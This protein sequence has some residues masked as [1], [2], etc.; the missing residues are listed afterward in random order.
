MI[1]KFKEKTTHLTPPLI[2]LK[3]HTYLVKLI[4]D[5]FTNRQN[6]VKFKRYMS[7]FKDITIGV[8]QDSVLGPIL[9]SLFISDFNPSVNN[10]KYAD[11]ITLYHLTKKGDCKGYYSTGYHANIS[12]PEINHLQQALDCTSNY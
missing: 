12:Y 4:Q 9:W 10:V 5:F 7:S 2:G 3:V 1:L 11:D 8:P 6:C